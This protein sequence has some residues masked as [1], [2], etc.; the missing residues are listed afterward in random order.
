[1]LLKL[2]LDHIL[3]VIRGKKELLQLIKLI[4]ISGFILLALSRCNFTGI[5]L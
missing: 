1:M 2:C 3:L 4:R 5:L